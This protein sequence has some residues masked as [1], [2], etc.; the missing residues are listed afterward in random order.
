MARPRQQEAARYLSLVQEQYA[1]FVT[2]SHVR[3]G[4]PADKIKNLVEAERFH[5]IV[6]T[7]RS[8]G[9]AAWALGGVANEMIEGPVPVSIAPPAARASHADETVEGAMAQF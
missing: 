8:R 1:G 5:L 2:G 9:E 6:M 7:A 4:R 3:T